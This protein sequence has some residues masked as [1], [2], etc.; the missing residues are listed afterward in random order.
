MAASN[1]GTNRRLADFLFTS[2]FEFD[3]FQAV[4]LLNMLG[5]NGQPARRDALEAVRFCAYNSLS[6][7]ASQ[8]ASIDQEKGGPPRMSVNFLGLTGPHG[9]LPVAYTELAVERE[10][11]GDRSFADFLDIFNH[12]LIELFF[13]AWQKH[14]FVIGYEHARR[15][16]LADDAFTTY[17]FDLIGMG[18]KGLRGRLPIRD[19][20]L[21]H[22]AGL[23][24]QKPHSAETLRAFLH[25]YF[26]V[27]VSVEQ[28]VGK[29]HQLEPEEACCL[30]SGER[31]SSLGDGAVAGDA[32]WT[33]EAL[34]RVALGPLTL[35][36]FRQFLADKKG[37]EEAIAL[38]RWFI[39]STLDFELRVVLRREDVPYCEIGTDPSDAR[40]GWSSWLSTETFASHAG[41]TL[42]RE[43][44]LVR[45]EA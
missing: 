38:I 40:L 6:F 28:L 45:L 41:D 24:S 42:F 25:D 8:I 32:V 11:F 34:M 5:E 33:R 36:Q 17:L 19:L 13:H 4:R 18:T 15:K 23:I 16:S 43:E 20:G 12:R 37:F 21:L 1:W 39:G 14:H 2:A 35:E 9:T 30:G 3:F 44:E 7:P 10:C 26:E 22:Y 29:W 27:P 31:S